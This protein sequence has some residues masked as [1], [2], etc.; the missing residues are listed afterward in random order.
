MRTIRVSYETRITT[1]TTVTV[2]TEVIAADETEAEDQGA[3]ANRFIQKFIDGMAR[4]AQDD[5]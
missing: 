5:A 3:A 1:D 4:S 2:E